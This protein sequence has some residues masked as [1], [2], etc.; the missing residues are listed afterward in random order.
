MRATGPIVAENE[1]IL[2]GPSVARWSRKAR[3]AYEAEREALLLLLLVFFYQCKVFQS[4][5]TLLHERGRGCVFLSEISNS[6]SLFLR[7]CC[8]PVLCF[9]FGT[10]LT[11]N[12]KVSTLRTLGMYVRTAC[13]RTARVAKR[14]CL[15]TC[16]LRME[17][18]LLALSSRQFATTPIKKN[19][20]QQMD[21]CA[22][23]II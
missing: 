5:R 19:V 13:E 11:R 17:A 8:C 12:K 21:L 9:R 2:P 23:R 6:F 7:C 3:A 22:L 4:G 20:S 14:M 10:A 16:F 1:K 18:G 15:P